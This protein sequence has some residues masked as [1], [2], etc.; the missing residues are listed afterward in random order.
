M[1]KKA[2]AVSLC[3]FFISSVGAQ[4]AQSTFFYGVV[5]LSNNSPAGYMRIELLRS[6]G[7]VASSEITNASGQFE[8]VDVQG[9]P[10][11]YSIRIVDGSSSVRLQLSLAEYEATSAT[12]ITNE[13][14]VTFRLSPLSE[15]RAYNVRNRVAAL[16]FGPHPD[17]NYASRIGPRRIEGYRPGR[18]IIWESLYIT[19]RGGQEVQG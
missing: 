12:T 2:I 16:A 10:N 6:D 14:P 3:A 1:N 4:V 11:E 15:P 17:A 5:L 9:V 8:F 19:A 13:A 18:N 7:S